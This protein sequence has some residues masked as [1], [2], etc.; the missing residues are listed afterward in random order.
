M[1]ICSTCAIHLPLIT[2][3][4]D[5]TISPG[6]L[7]MLSDSPVIQDSLTNTLPDL[8]IESVIT[9]LPV[10]NSTKSSKTISLTSICI[11]LPFLITFALVLD[12]IDNLSI[13]RLEWTSWIVLIA[14]LITTISKNNIFL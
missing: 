6:F 13:T 2:K 8:I 10:E 7:V 14:V 11:L 9:W 12:I 1:P 5:K 3:L 4:P